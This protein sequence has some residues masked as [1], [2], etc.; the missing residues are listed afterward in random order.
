[1]ISSKL[2]ILDNVQ[3]VRNDI[4]NRIKFRQLRNPENEFWLT[5]SVKKGSSRKKIN[6]IEISDIDHFKEQLIKVIHRTYANSQYYNFITEYIFRINKIKTEKLWEFNKV[7]LEILFEMLNLDLYYSLSSEI[8]GSNLYSSSE[9][10]TFLTIKSGYNCYLSG[11]GG[12][13]YIDKNI[14]HTNNIKLFWHPWESP[15][16][17]KELN[18]DEISFIDFIARYGPIELKKYIVKERY[19][20]DSFE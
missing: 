20:E 15:K 17:H 8:E 11:L 10:L 5:C 19:Y 18:W 13:N 12:L 1:M 3:F 6:E 2:I 9:K 16:E 4:Q 7:S 14:F